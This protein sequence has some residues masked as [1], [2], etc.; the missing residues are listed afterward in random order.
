ML[1]D[2]EANLA[3]VLHHFALPPVAGQLAKSPTLT[4]YSK[5]PEQ[6]AFSPEARAQLMRRSRD[7]FAAE[8]E[9]GLI[10]IT[11][12]QSSAA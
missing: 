2:L 5:A 1:A 12:L 3:Q 10:L 8:I 6:L 4:R 11:K 7:M 9:K